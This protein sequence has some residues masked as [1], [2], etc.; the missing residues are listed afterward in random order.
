MRGVVTPTVGSEPIPY[1]ASVV[2]AVL[3]ALTVTP[4]AVASEST[5]AWIV[6]SLRETRTT[7]VP[8][9]NDLPSASMGWAAT[10]RRTPRASR[11]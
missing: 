4:K 6:V 8:R 2:Y 10:A 9:G 5:R 11:A 1:W 3:T 7:Q